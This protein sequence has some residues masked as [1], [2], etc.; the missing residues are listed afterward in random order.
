MTSLENALAGG[1][2]NIN[3]G[4]T[5]QILGQAN[6]INALQQGGAPPVFDPR[7]MGTALGQLTQAGPPLN[8]VRQLVNQYAAPVP[9]S[10]GLNMVRQALQ[11][12]VQNPALTQGLSA[13]VRAMIGM[14][15]QDAPQR[16]GGCGCG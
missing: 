8:P 16:C 1:I 5:D 15:L 3:A 9:P 4:F 10:F 13:P 2:A 11:A 7:L 14:V 12:L 6:R